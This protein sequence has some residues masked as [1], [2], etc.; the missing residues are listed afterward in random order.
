MKSHVGTDAL[1]CSRGSGSRTGKCARP[2]G[3][4]SPGVERQF[5]ML[6]IHADGRTRLEL[7]A[8]EGVLEVVLDH[9]AEGAGSVVRVEAFLGQ[10][11]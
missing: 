11:R 4:R 8:E 7:A 1:H 5:P 10:Q 6:L 2:T 3:R 9:A